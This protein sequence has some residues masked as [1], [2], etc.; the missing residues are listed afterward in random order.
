MDAY[1]QQVGYIAHKI[2]EVDNI[3]NVMLEKYLPA[4]FCS[5]M[6][7]GCIER[8]KDSLTWTH[9]GASKIIFTGTT[10]VA[11]SLAAIKKYVFDEKSI[12]MEELIEAC[13]TNFEGKEELRQML[14]NKA[15]KYGNDDDYVDELAREVHVRTNE[16]INK[17][18]RDR[19]DFPFYLDASIAG[20][21][22]TASVNCGALPDGKLDGEPT[23]DASHSP[24]AGTDRYGPTAVLKSAGKIPF[25]YPALLN[26]KFLPR[27]LEGESKKKFAQYLRTW[28]DLGIGHI[29]FNVIDKATL[30]DAQAHPERYT[31]LV[32]RVAGYSAYFVDLAK[33]LQDD[34]IRRTEQSI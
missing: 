5:I 26:Q 14:V 3:R 9:Y 27:F 28:A 1:L 18:A 16:V 10:N 2:A 19:W 34:I 33:P 15:P 29:Q 11:N 30:L 23:A 22:F 13:R 17:C 31:N 32:V 7:D 8:G 25:T 6:I 21:Y 12:T 20:G 4:P 24:S